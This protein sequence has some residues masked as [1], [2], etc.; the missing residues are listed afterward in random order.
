M[1]GLIRFVLIWA[2]ARALAPKL[3]RLFDRLIVKAPEG[4]FVR[5]MLGDLRDRQSTTIIRSF[6]ETAGELVFGPKGKGR[7]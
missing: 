1:K 5:A 7:G 4:S 3:N 6:G 2:L